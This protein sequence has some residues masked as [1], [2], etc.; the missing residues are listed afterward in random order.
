[1][2]SVCSVAVPEA[3]STA[4]AA[5]MASCARPSTSVTLAPARSTACSNGLTRT[6]RVRHRA[7]RSAAPD[8]SAREP[9][10]AAGEVCAE[11]FHFARAAAGQQRDDLGVLRQTQRAARRPLG[12]RSGMRS[13]SG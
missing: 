11:A 6:R 2:S 7:R 1:M 8:A 13:A 5:A 12:E 4:S 9:V 10:G 3:T